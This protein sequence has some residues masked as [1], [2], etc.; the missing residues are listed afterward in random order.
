MVII[1][2][3]FVF[4]PETFWA[5]A[6]QVISSLPPNL[7]LHA[8]FPSKDLK[9]GTCIWEAERVEEVQEFLDN[10]VGNISRN[11]CYQV[12]EEIAIGLPQQAKQ[13]AMS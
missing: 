9:S 8:V 3:H 6:S 10:A 12:A 13:E 1:A 7:K 11:V 5:S 4:D 2:Q